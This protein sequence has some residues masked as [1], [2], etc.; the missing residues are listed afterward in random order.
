MSTKTRF[1]KKVQQSNTVTEPDERS[2]EADIQAFCRR[3]ESFARQLSHWFE[4]S[5]IEVIVAKKYLHDLS[6]IG[7]SL[8]SGAVCYEITTLTLRHGPRS[9]TIMPEQLRQGREKGCVTLTVDSAAGV[10]GKQKYS[11]CM[12]PE[13]GWLIR[14]EAQTPADSIPLTEDVFFQTIEKLA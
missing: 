8:N 9:V 7:Y 10:A 2:L 13:S 6:T 1:F 4:G 5:A 11:L 12:A 3:M 14:E